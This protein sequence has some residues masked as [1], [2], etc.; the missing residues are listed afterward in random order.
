MLSPLRNRFGIPG[1]ISVL[2]LVFAMLGGAYAASSSEDGKATASAK[3]KRGPKGPKGAKGATG[4]AGPVGPQ[5]PAGANGKDG[6]NGSNGSNGAPGTAGKDGDDGKSVISTPF[7]G[8]EELPPFEGQCEGAGGAELE[9]EGSGEVETVCN[10]TDGSGSDVLSGVWSADGEEGAAGGTIPIQAAISYGQTIEPAPEL[11]YVPVPGGPFREG[12]FFGMVVDTE[13]GTRTAQFLSSGEIEARCGT[14]ST[15]NP[16][17]EPGYLC[18][19]PEAEDFEDPELL[20]PEGYFQMMISDPASSL[21]TW[22]SPDPESGAIVPFTLEEFDLGV[23]SEGGS[24][25]GSW[26]VN[27]K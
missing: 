6:A 14:G 1:V 19:F 10:G 16:S 21:D 4:P 15:A 3:A 13:T 22:V 26:A 18:V 2:A 23:D 27:V 20:V 5:G 8:E 9:V 25:K 7:S 11:V 17:A 24:I 12:G